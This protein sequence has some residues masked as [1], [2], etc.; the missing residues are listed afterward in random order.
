M[1]TQILFS[2]DY[3]PLTSIIIL[4]SIIFVFSLLTYCYV[5]KNT[6]ND[7]VE[8]KKAVAKN[9]YYFTIAAVI[10]FVYNV[11]PSASPSIK[12][13]LRDQGIIA[14]IVINYFFQVF[15]IIPS[16]A[17]P[18]AAIVILNPLHFA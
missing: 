8:T 7:N 5:K 1:V 16:L 2:L 10:T 17:S 14:I 18:I 3:L 4:L 11:A 12:T 9:L 15:F 13:A 6:L